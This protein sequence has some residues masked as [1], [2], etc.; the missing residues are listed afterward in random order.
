MCWTKIARRA[1]LFL[2]C[3]LM[4][5]FPAAAPSALAGRTV[6]L[7][8][9]DLFSL[10]DW[11]HQTIAV[12]GLTLDITKEQVVEIAKRKG[13]ILRNKQMLRKV[14]EPNVPCTQRVCGIDKLGGPWI[15]LDL[16]F[17][18]DR[19]NKIKVSVPAD[20]DA[21]VRSVNIAREFKGLTRQFFNNYSDDL[22][23]KILGAADE[24]KT[25]PKS[26]GGAEPFYT[27]IEY[28][29]PATGLAV[30]VTVS[31]TEPTPFDLEVDFTSLR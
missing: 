12:D 1:A 27:F 22:R 31:K 4:A 19:V 18:M 10:P 5:A 21:E 8:E 26:A 6:E 25:H 16:F 23:I 9:V 3:L 24:K 29:Y 15:G 30:H 20:A 28:D 13:L 2:A 17:D 14:G 11:E 7:T